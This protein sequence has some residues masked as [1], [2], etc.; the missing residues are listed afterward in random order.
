MNRSP[1][2]WKARHFVGIIAEGRP[3]AGTVDETML[4]R[5][6]ADESRQSRQAFFSLAAA[7]PSVRNRGGL[8]GKDGAR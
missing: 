7:Y 3:T 1:G 6:P 5:G 8:V 4:P 2:T